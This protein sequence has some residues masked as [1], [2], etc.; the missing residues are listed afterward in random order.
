MVIMI[1]SSVSV[2][3]CVFILHVHSLGP[4]GV[5]VPMW[6]HKFITRYLA[7]VVGMRYLVKPHETQLRQHYAVDRE[8]LYKG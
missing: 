4:K 6:L 1:I 7:R 2:A 8:G 5:R 3:M